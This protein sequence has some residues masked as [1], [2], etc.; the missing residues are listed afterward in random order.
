MLASWPATTL[1]CLMFKLVSGVRILRTWGAEPVKLSRGAMG[2]GSG[3]GD[4]ESRCE[5]ELCCEEMMLVHG[6]DF[7]VSML[8]AGKRQQQQGIDIPAEKRKENWAVR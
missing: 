1:A 4:E 6:P 7:F 8:E 5:V 2:I 3:L